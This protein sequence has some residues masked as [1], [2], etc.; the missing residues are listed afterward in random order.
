[1]LGGLFRG[2]KSNK[3]LNSA[4]PPSSQVQQQMQQ[5]QQLQQL[6]KRA[7]G[8]VN[9]VPDFDAKNRAMLERQAEMMRR[10]R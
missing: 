3:A 10:N 4:S 9:K 8:A 7:A 6:N 1:M 2:L 5:L